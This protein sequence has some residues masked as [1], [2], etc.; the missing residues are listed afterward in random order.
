MIKQSGARAANSPGIDDGC[1]LTVKTLSDLTSTSGDAIRY[2]TRIGLLRP[3]RDETN[4][5]RYFTAADTVRLKFI[6]RAKTLGYK[7]DEIGE[8]LA[9]SEHGSSPCPLVREI[10]ARRIE[11]HRAALRE[12]EALQARMEAAVRQWRDLPDGVPVGNSICHLIEQAT[13][14]TT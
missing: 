10:I 13:M 6:R 5:Y 4:G 1:G 2:Y 8:I 9:A 11:E 14:D 3:R 12:A 7:L